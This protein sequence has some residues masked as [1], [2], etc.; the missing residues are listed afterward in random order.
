MACAKAFSVGGVHET[1]GDPLQP[2]AFPLKER[3]PNP[4]FTGEPVIPESNEV[5][6]VLGETKIEVFSGTKHQG[7]DERRPD[8]FESRRRCKE[9]P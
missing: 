9:A 1:L 6:A 2:R 3:R 7:L 5:A 4:G 8:F